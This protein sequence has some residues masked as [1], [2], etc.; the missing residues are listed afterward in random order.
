MFCVMKRSLYP[1]ILFVLLELT[2][3]FALVMW[4]VRSVLARH[5]YEAVSR[6]ARTTVRELS[7]TGTATMVVGIVI[8][9][10]VMAGSTLLFAG[11][12][13]ERS[14]HRKRAEFFQSFSHELMTPLTSLQMNADLLAADL[15][16]ADQEEGKLTREQVRQLLEDMRSSSRRLERR[17]RNIIETT[18]FE[19]RRLRLQTEAVDLKEYARGFPSRSALVP[20]TTGIVFSVEAPG[21]GPA[22]AEVD[23]R[24]L[25][26]VLDNLFENAVKNEARHVELAVRV[27]GDRAELV[28]TD[29]GAGIDPR[30]LAGIFR[31]FFRGK[32]QTSRGSGL[33]LAV[34]RQIV[35][36][37]KGRITA[38]SEGPGRGATFTVSLPCAGEVNS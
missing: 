33:G 23:A 37:H 10:V 4:T 16:V 32:E 25:D 20:V 22:L 38:F 31:M 28:V 1:T 17:L 30:E 18:R 35:K 19:H 13:R 8:L 11:W 12:L 24:Y 21:E 14:L 3:I 27:A 29:D 2:L 6:I 7:F 15:L 34:C 26:I 36:L 9:A 5:E